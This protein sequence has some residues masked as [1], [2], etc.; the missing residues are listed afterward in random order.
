MSKWYSYGQ[1]LFLDAVL[2]CVTIYCGYIIGATW[3]VGVNGD[4]GEV[5]KV[6]QE[7]AREIAATSELECNLSCNYIHAPYI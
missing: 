4:V 7:R 6:V 5:L 1:L 3:Y 2:A